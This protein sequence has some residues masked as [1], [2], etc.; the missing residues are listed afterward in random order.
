M[1]AFRTG[2]RPSFVAAHG[3]P[4]A[5]IGQV[6]V[7]PV[8]PG[9]AER[10]DLLGL[11]GD[12][13]DVAVL[14]VAAGGGPLEVGVELDAVRRVQVDALHLAAQPLALGEAGHHLERVAEDHPV[15]PAL[16][17]L[18]ELGLV[19]ARGDAVEVGEEV[20][21]GAALGAGAVAA[22]AGKLVDQRL[23]VHLLL[24]VERRRRHH[25]I[26]PIL[27]VLAAPDELR[28]EVA[29]A[30]L[31]GHPQRALLLLFHQRLVLGG[32]DV[33]ARV[34]AVLQLFDDARLHAAR[35]LLALLPRAR[36]VVYPL[37]RQ[38]RRRGA[39]NA[40]LFLDREQS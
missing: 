8:L 2:M 25:Q 17:V 12:V 19:S 34:V 36:H 9:V 14:H 15:R 7:N 21:V 26:A 16:V 11:A 33:L 27:L 32:G 23:G 20:Q 6:A 28:I 4:V 22:L 1:R 13:G 24:D 31:P 3:E 39:G 29:I 35:A 37:G 30:P 40:D 38:A 18:V 5:Q 10:L